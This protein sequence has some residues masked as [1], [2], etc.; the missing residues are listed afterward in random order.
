MNVGLIF[1]FK[2]YLDI[3]YQRL[4]NGD[5]VLV[6]GFLLCSYTVTVLSGWQGNSMVPIRPFLG[7]ILLTFGPGSL[8]LG[9]IGMDF[10]RP[11]SIIYIV[12]SSLGLLMVAGFVYNSLYLAFPSFLF[13]TFSAPGLMI[14]LFVLLGTVSILFLRSDNDPALP[15]VTVSKAAT[16]LTLF[17]ATLPI[18]SIAGTL[19]MN[20]QTENGFLIALF[21][22]IA[23]VPIFL[24][25]GDYTKEQNMFVIYCVS[26]SLV[27]Q[28]TLHG[29]ITIPFNPIEFYHVNVA[30][31]NLYWNVNFA[32]NKNAMLHFS[33]LHPIY[34]HVLGIRPV[35]GF[36][37]LYPL[38]FSLLGPAV[39]LTYDSYFPQGTSLLATFLLMFSFIYFFRLSKLTRTGAAVFFVSVYFLYLVDSY[40]DKRRT[41]ILALLALFSTV[42]SHYGITPLVLFI[43]VVC[44][45]VGTIE[46]WLIGTS[47]RTSYVPSSHILFFGVM[48]V[49][50]YLYTADGF[51]L[52]IISS[53]LINAI[54]DAIQGFSVQAS[55]AGNV[56]TTDFESYTN[57]FIKFEYILITAASGL[58][59][60]TTVLKRY[61]HFLPVPVPWS[62]PGSPRTEGRMLMFGIAAGFLL[63]AAFLPTSIIGIARIYG[64]VLI[65]IAPF[66][67]QG[68]TD[69][70]G[71]IPSVPSIQLVSLRNLLAIF[72]VCSLLINAGVPA[73]LV[74][75]EDSPKTTLDE[76]YITNHGSISDLRRLDSSRITTTDAYAS[77]WIV[78][79]KS[80]LPV[81]GPP[82]AFYSHFYTTEYSTRNKPGVNYVRITP[83]S[84]SYLDR[85]PA[86]LYYSW[87]TTETG[88]IPLPLSGN[89]RGPGRQAFLNVSTI[90]R[91]ASNLIYHSKD[92]KLFWKPSAN[93]CSAD[94]NSSIG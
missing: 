24:I 82:T 60:T 57:K 72:L 32:T 80:D 76:K 47:D 42:V 69:V 39:Y 88:L 79:Y 12:A 25:N 41:S 15:A 21:V 19:I 89:K 73:T 53:V 38:W 84:I 43:L 44:R 31:E 22:L 91:C 59:I 78:T 8:L 93:K 58:G 40:N 66:A 83:E 36:R 30:Y 67:I 49:T 14:I 90:E 37:T 52:K 50:W 7:F 28:T 18:T 2:S 13:K 77:Q 20:N 27:L 35:L 48:F 81:F 1:W 62:Q 63:V 17:A 11:E 55:D 64:L 51:T 46:Q 68:V 4:R 29:S 61:R 94:K 5:L 71:V 92:A 6:V 45:V 26:L 54:L 74:F 86:Y 33:I 85:N 9:T 23:F 10:D 34:D 16:P 75:H 70:V 65:F 56:A 3:Q 87:F